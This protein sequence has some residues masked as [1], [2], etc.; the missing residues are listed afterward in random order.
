MP[1]I[2]RL[3]FPGIQSD[4][5]ARSAIIS[6][7]K[8]EQFKGLTILREEAEINALLANSGAERI[9]FSWKNVGI[10]WIFFLSYLLEIS[11]FFSKKLTFSLQVFILVGWLNTLFLYFGIPYGLN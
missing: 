9:M 11:V 6:V 1:I 7:I 10:Q 5:T 3:V 4:G 2:K 8:E